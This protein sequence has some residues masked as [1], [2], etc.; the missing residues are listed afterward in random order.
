MNEKDYKAIAEIFRKY[1]K[2]NQEGKLGLSPKYK[3]GISS[4]LNFISFDLADYFE[5]ELGCVC[6]HKIHK[7]FCQVG[8]CMCFK[9]K[10]IFNREQFLK[11]CG[12]K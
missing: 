1:D 12:V 5:K 9:C 4:A 6:T 10:P 7:K 3:N 8:T 11:D 2:L